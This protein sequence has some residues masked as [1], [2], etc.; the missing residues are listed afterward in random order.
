MN[1]D[2]KNAV[3]ALKEFTDTYNK[4]AKETI[5][6]KMAEEEGMYFINPI[7]DKDG[8]FDKLPNVICL[9]ESVGEKYH[10]YYRKRYCKLKY[11]KVDETP[12][13]IEWKRGCSVCGS[14]ELKK[15][16]NFCPNCGAEVVK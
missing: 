2:M 15:Q 3:I 6:L 10:S 7:P 8:A 11:R 13:Y 14:P 1:D 16:H 9:D 5:G 4:I 12:W